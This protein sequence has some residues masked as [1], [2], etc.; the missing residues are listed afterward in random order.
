MNPYQALRAAAALPGHA[1]L[2]LVAVPVSGYAWARNTTAAV[3]EVLVGSQAVVHRIQALLELI[4][5][6]VAEVGATN[7]RAAAVAARADGLTAE[8]ALL[9]V[10]FQDQAARSAS[11]LAQVES[12]MLAASPTAEHAA[13][14][15]RP[16]H[17]DGL[18][19]LLELVPDLLDLIV[20]AFRGLSELSPDLDEL[21]ERL[22]T[23]GQI[24][25][26]L[27]GAALLRRRG[28]NEQAE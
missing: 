24:V 10:E 26:G 14:V 16:E 8:S 17:V 18:V 28:S 15:V 11:V 23:V 27:P 4:E 12:L 9:L 6:L 2:S 19:R 1:A 13:A 20:P 7:E 5:S 25:E 22:D 21:T 3:T